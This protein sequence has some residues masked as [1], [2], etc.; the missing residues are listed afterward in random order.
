MGSIVSIYFSGYGVGKVVG[1]DWIGLMTDRQSEYGES[2][3]GE[4]EGNTC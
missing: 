2:A 3:Y 4:A 1:G